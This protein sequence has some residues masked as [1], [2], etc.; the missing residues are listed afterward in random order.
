MTGP[1]NTLDRS[2]CA[3][4]E[5]PL[6]PSREIHPFR[7][8]TDRLCSNTIN[9]FDIYWITGSKK[10]IVRVQEPQAYLATKCVLT[11]KKVSPWS[12]PRNAIFGPSPMHCWGSF[13]AI[14]I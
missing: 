7:V 14:P 8:I 9:Y 4:C 2:L 10:V 3:R 6:R 13:R 1:V 11:F 12:L 5:L